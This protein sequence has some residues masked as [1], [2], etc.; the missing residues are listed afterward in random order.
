MS[1]SAMN[2][3]LAS[4]LFKRCFLNIISSEL[5]LSHKVPINLSIILHSMKPFASGSNYFQVSINIS[6]SNA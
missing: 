5:E 1:K 4:V 2:F 3:L 6:M